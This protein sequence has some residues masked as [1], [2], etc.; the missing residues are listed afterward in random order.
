MDKKIPRCEER[1]RSCET[2]TTNGV[3][4]EFRREQGC[5]LGY[6]ALD[7]KNPPLRGEKEERRE[8]ERN[9]E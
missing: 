1:K 5:L 8:K 4:E 7:K 2:L 3:S 6:L 9:R